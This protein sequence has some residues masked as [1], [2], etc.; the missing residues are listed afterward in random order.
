MHASSIEN[1]YK[2]FIRYVDVVKFYDQEKTTVLDIGGSN[3]NGSYQCIFSDHQFE[4]KTVDMVQDESVDVVLDDP[5]N[6][7]FQENSIDVVICGQTFEHVE[8]F[9]L[10]FE[11]MI[12]IVK[13][14]G[15][16]FL[17]APSSGPDHKYP[18]DCYRFYPDSYNA[19]AKY[20]NCFLVD[21]WLDDR[22]PWNDLVGVFKKTN[23]PKYVYQ[24]NRKNFFQSEYAKQFEPNILFNQ[25]D[26]KVD[27]I[28]GDINYL[29]IIGLIHNL[30]KPKMYFEIG[31][32]K[33]KSLSYS[34]CP[35]IAVDPIP[36]IDTN[37]YP[38]VKL[39]KI[40]SDDF[41]EH[42]AQAELN[43]NIDLAFIDGMHLFEFV[44]R[45]FINIER[46]AISDSIIIIDDIFPNKKIQA[47][48]KRQSR[49]WTGD[50]W[51]IQ[52][53][54]KKYR[55]DLRIMALNTSPTGLLL[56]SG[57]NAKNTILKSNYN[58][59]VNYYKNL[60]IKEY[61]EEL[62]NRKYAE[63]VSTALINS[64]IKS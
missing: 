23:C 49:V 33:G 25:Y 17:I 15:F 31:I 8:F 22:G 45:D 3:V 38:N 40:T 61:E 26:E 51:K 43:Q 57:L 41:F 60:G 18:V 4:Y 1:M 9:W 27:I 56:V 16:V 7:P 36:D 29:H 35:S 5:Y 30:L 24:E 44:L 28:K 37:Q 2:C 21:C 39:F 20:S 42:Y 14:D 64:F 58:P 53:C 48:R 47:S 62:F 10:L 55:P 6:L 11:E 13:A 54:L 52:Y 46:H 59:I 63:D 50:V 19:L 12:R 32:R 34:S